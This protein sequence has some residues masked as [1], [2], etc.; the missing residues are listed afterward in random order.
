MTDENIDVS[1]S[2]CKKFLSQ[3]G[4]RVT[5]EATKKFEQMLRKWSAEVSTKATQKAVDNK[6]KTID[7]RDLED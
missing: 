7:V 6:R 4:M 5:P 2:M 1:L 3:N